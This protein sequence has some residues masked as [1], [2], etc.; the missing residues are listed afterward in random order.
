MRARMVRGNCRTRDEG[1][2]D[3]FKD[4]WQEFWEDD[5]GKEHKRNFY[6][7]QSKKG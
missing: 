3:L 7:K 1:P 2:L 5:L 4:V 6:S